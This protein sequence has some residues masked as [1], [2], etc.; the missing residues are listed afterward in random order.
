MS[1]QA[2]VDTNL[3]GS[4]AC[5]QAGIYDLAGNPWA[6]SA[7]FAAQVAEVAA[8]SAHMAS[9]ATALAGTGLII[10]GEKYMFVRGDADCVVGKKGASGVIIY[11]CNTCCLVATHGEQ[12]I[13]YPQAWLTSF[14]CC[15]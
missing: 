15:R 14:S 6:Y 4:G 3:L 7:G 13:A 12:P 2:Y 11:R 5:T 9:D 10:A 1:W 8:I